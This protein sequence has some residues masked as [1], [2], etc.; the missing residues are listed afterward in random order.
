M[1]KLIGQIQDDSRLIL[2]QRIYIDLFADLPTM[3]NLY[4]PDIGCIR[5]YCEY[6]LLLVTLQVQRNV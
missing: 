4:Q 2:L 1:F 5:K 6:F 3:D